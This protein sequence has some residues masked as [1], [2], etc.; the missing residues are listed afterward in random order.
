VQ[1]VLIIE[2]LERMH[3]MLPVVYCCSVFRTVQ[4]KSGIKINRRVAI[5]ITALRLRSSVSG[6]HTL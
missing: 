4:F 2:L 5:S 3:G 1:H 6:Q